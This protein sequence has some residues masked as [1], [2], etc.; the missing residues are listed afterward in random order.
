MFINFKCF[1]LGAQIVPSTID[2]FYGTYNTTGLKFKQFNK[3]N[4]GRAE[5]TT[6]AAAAAAAAANATA[7]TKAQ[8]LHKPFPNHWQFYLSI[9]PKCSW[10]MFLK[11][12]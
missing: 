3:S 11:Q 6:T 10:F 1:S 8:Q 4:N 7:P 2:N 9:F 5:A 12:H